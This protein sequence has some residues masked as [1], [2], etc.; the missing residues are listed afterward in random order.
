MSLL[1]K[2]QISFVNC[3][4]T[5]YLATE[6]LMPSVNFLVFLDLIKLLKASA[7]NITRKW[8]F[9]TVTAHMTLQPLF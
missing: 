4:I 8:P 1:M 7:A 9:L 3:S 6:T 5:T 2:L